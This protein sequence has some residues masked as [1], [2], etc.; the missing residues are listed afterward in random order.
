MFPNMKFRFKEL[1]ELRSLTSQDPECKIAD[2]IDRVKKKNHLVLLDLLKEDHPV[3]QERS[4]NTV[5]KLRGYAMAAMY[6]S[7]TPAGAIPYLRATLETERTPYLVA[8]AARALR[9]MAPVVY[10]VPL[11]LKSIDNI[12]LRDDALS[13]SE[14]QPEWPILN[15]TTALQ[16]LLLTIQY[17]GSAAVAIKQDLAFLVEQ[18]SYDFNEEILREI[19]ATVDFL[20]NV[21]EKPLDCCD[22]VLETGLQLPRGIFF[23]RKK[24]CA[25]I[26][27]EDQEEHSQSLSQL[28]NN[29]VTVLTFFYTRCENPLKCSMTISRLAHLSAAIKGTSLENQVNI[30]G[31]SYDATFDTPKELE[32]Y[33][34]KRGCEFSPSLRLLRVTKG[35]D[36]LKKMLSLGV[37]YIG[38]IVNIHKN[39][40]YIL[41]ANG[42]LIQSFTHQKWDV[43]AV[44]EAL[45]SYFDQLPAAGRTHRLLRQVKSLSKTFYAVIFPLLFAFF[46]KCP[47]CWAAYLTS[48]GLSGLTFIPYT[49][50]FYPV[51]LVIIGVNLYVLFKRAYKR[52]SYL[53]CIFSAAGFMLVMIFGGLLKIQPAIYVGIFFII[54]GS[55]LNSFPVNYT[56]FLRVQSSR[57]NC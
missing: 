44:N 54:I 53:P 13:F 43:A 56:L 30:F 10:L 32:T 5:V 57:N 35:Y 20:S 25:N 1:T 16:E 15:Y 36:T 2:F 18:R 6:V 48:F 14:Y 51:I 29:K 52:N 40:L 42:R 55:L 17:Y 39:E 21:R 8:A 46:P 26:I 4:S 28:L 47:L 27:I 22:E 7:G 49:P 41:D 33:G 37:S 11:L 38:Y 31:I 12:R 3:Y 24:A 50:W 19:I 23:N 9:G 34:L 45:K